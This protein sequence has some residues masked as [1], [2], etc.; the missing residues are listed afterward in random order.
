MVDV[1][2]VPPSQLTSVLNC[3]LTDPKQSLLKGKEDA[4][5]RISFQL[6]AVWCL[7]TM[8]HSIQS[9]REKNRQEMLE[10]ITLYFAN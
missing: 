9:K 5:N 6:C 7:S 2:F 8:M 4:S 10:Q 1:S 3:R